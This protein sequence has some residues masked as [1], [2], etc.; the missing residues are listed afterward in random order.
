M[1]ILPLQESYSKY[2]TKLAESVVCDMALKL[3][4]EKLHGGRFPNLFWMIYHPLYIGVLGEDR[5]FEL[6]L[7]R[8]LPFFQC[9]KT[10]TVRIQ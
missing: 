6:D 4:K 9:S 10:Y 3:V 5:S 8:L 1:K 7:H 2:T